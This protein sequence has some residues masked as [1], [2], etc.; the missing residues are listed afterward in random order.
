MSSD[1]HII[2]LTSPINPNL[3]QN[4]S[5]GQW[6]RVVEAACAS[7][8]ILTQLLTHIFL[9]LAAASLCLLLGHMILSIHISFP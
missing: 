1:N 3:V 7:S 2:T 4:N 6:G 5:F 9:A 8:F